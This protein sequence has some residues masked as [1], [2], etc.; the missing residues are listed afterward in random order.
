MVE[1]SNIGGYA[2]EYLNGVLNILILMVEI[3][4]EK[5]LKNLKRVKR[6]SKIIL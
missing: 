3:M 4:L 5:L 2:A 1:L 6:K